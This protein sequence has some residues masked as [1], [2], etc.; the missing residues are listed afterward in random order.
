MFSMMKMNSMLIKYA[1]FKLLCW[2]GGGEWD[3][4]FCGSKRKY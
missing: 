3:E 4:W 1:Y 2:Y